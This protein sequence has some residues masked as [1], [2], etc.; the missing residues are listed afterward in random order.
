MCGCE[1]STTPSFQFLPHQ[2]TLN[3]NS[4]VDLDQDKKSELIFWNTSSMSK[5]SEFLEQ[6]FFETVNLTKNSYAKL[7]YGEV[8]DVPFIG[9]FDEDSVIDYG[10]YRSYAQSVSNWFIKSGASD[11]HLNISFG[12]AWDLPVP[13]DYDGDKRDDIAV[14]SS[15]SSSFEGIFSSNG[16]PFRLQLGV[17]GDIPVPKDYDGDGKA[18]FATYRQRNGVWTIRTS[19]GNKI[20]EVI[21]GGPNFL[22]IPSDYDGD[23]KADLCVWNNLD[24]SINAILSTHKKPL[25]KNITEKIKN[26]LNDKDFFP[27]SSDYD[28]DGTSELAFWNSALKILV[29][30][31][32]ENELKQKTYHFPK[33]T[34]SFPVSN[35]LLR[36]VLAK[37]APILLFK[38]GEIVKYE[39][40]EQ[41]TE[42][43]LLFKLDKKENI[44]PF[45]SDFD[46]DYELDSC[47]WSID[48]GTFLCT[49][50]RVGWDFALPIGQKT[51]LPIIGDF[52]GDS[53]TDLGMYRSQTKE[54]YYRFLG[55]FAPIDIQMI[56]LNSEVS[57][58]S[59]PQI[60][61]YD[62]DD[63]ADFAIYD[64]KENT[65]VINES[66][67]SQ[68]VKI[69]LCKDT[70]CGSVPIVG[71][72]DGD[73]K[74]DPGTIDLELGNFNYN[75][76]LY[77][78]LVSHLIDSELPEMF[79]SAHFDNDLK[80]DLVFLDTNEEILGIAE[81]SNNFKYKKIKILDYTL[82]GAKFVK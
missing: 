6:C 4:L 70:R 59:I 82:K 15:S 56:Q 37:Q 64:P 79:V 9:Y 34:N 27:V 68:I 36:R 31:S 51:D 5:P 22:P 45:V 11:N 67:T 63:K 43:S 71:D 77:S 26:K 55:K 2:S 23:G 33:I 35:F 30:F 10:V 44:I 58:N 16:L 42:N 60:A 81:S 18:D 52:N 40:T 14:Y 20:S 38:D 76:S 13:T 69:N 66:S 25:E 28:G 75:S 53:I 12:H 8:A 54:F 65:F 32:I 24:N 1:N 41:N 47:L 74:S 17:K 57:E 29:S 78:S 7:T 62:G 3:I 72:F 46:G 48:T 50:S 73:G 21:L 61:D 49:S 19:R 80:S 39:R